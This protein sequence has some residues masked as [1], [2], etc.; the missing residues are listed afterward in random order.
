M[1]HSTDD[2]DA[3]DVRDALRSLRMTP[4]Y[5]SVANCSVAQAPQDSPGQHR[6]CIR[7]PQGHPRWVY[8]PCGHSRMGFKDLYFSH[9]CLA[10]VSL[11]IRDFYDNI[12]GVLVGASDHW[13][14]G[15]QWI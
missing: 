8:G 13:I 3:K 6:G 9:G 15:S 2:K 10:D 1:D 4:G 7:K 12:K 5:T 11:P 14:P